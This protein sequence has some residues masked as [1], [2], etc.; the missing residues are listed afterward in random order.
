MKIVNNHF[1]RGNGYVFWRAFEA[2]DTEYAFGV[3]DGVLGYQ[4]SVDFGDRDFFQLEFKKGNFAGDFLAKAGPIYSRH[5]G[6]VALGSD[7][8]TV[9]QSAPAWNLPKERYTDWMDNDRIQ[10]K[11]LFDASQ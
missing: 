1:L 2:W 9:S 4:D 6:D 5:G 8:S 3:R 7:G 10:N 11:M